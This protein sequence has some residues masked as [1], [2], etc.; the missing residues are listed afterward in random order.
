MS[1]L[2]LALDQGTTSS[3]AVVVD[4][5]GRFVGAA[6]REF[7]QHFP[8]PGWVEHDPEEIWRTQRDTARAAIETAGVR[9][10]DIAAVG[11]TNQRETVVVW[12]RTGGAPLAPAIVWQDRRT[13]DVVAR[14]KAEGREDEVR[15]V[16]GLLLDPYFSATKIAWILDRVPGARERAERGEL[17]AGTIDSWL[18][19]KLTDGRVHATDVTNAS[20]TQLMD[21]RTLDWH[22]DMLRLFR[23]P[24]SVLPE[25][26]SCDADFGRTSSEHLG[27]ALPVRAMVGDQQA[28]LFGQ[29]CERPGMAKNTFGT[30]CFMLM[31]VGERVPESG[32]RLLATVAWR[33]GGTGASYALEGSTF[34]GGSAVQWLRDGLGLI[35]SAAEVNT[36]AA[37]VPDSGGVVVVPAFTGLGAPHWDPLARGTI[38]GLTRGSTAAHLARATLEGI[39][40]QVADLLE[41]MQADAG[42]GIE[43]LRVD[44]GASASD[45]LMQMQA[46]LIGIP[47]HRPAQVESTACGAAFM[48]GLAAGVWRQAADIEPLVRIDRVFEPSIDEGV[49]AQT[50]DRWRRA[51]DR[52]KA[53]ETEGASS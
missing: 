10:A 44:G 6:Q 37:Q 25:I 45:L 24:R 43:V 18:L 8:R 27:A 23:V 2:L 17:A 34:V 35:R 48:A 5:T 11:V 41:A 31:Q 9:A 32:H 12:E 39:A 22:E 16:T 4:A 14:L 30:G 15:R 40:H 50:R 28:A 52:A 46:D 3:R 51:V 1:G 38:V 20:R 19:W 33:R 26:R 36:L 49:R 21:L 53:W 29:R 47:V 7:Q 13:V 42:R